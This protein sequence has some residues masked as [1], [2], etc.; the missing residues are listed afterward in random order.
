MKSLSV[1]CAW[2]VGSGLAAQDA[3]Q[4]ASAGSQDVGRQVGA[5]GPAARMRDVG[6]KSEAEACQLGPAL[7]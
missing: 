7:P 1:S 3:G 5:A 2:C 6:S 4:G